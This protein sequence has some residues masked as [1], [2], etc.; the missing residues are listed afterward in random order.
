MHSVFGTFHK[1]SFPLTGCRIFILRRKELT[2][3]KVTYLFIQ[4]FRRHLLLADS[5]GGPTGPCRAICRLNRTELSPAT[6]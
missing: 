6:M 3:A 5:T 1:A 4:L 2:L